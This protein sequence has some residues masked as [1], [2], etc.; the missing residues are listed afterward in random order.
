MQRTQLNGTNWLFLRLHNGA[1]E[2]QC[3]SAEGTNLPR[4]TLTP[5][6]YWR[7]MDVGELDL[8]GG[9]TME[10]P[11]S[12][13]IID[14]GVRRWDAIDGSVF[15]KMLEAELGGRPETHFRS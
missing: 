8:P 6:L 15:A 11:G 13:V 10:Y 9:V 5:E 12:Y 7:L 4:I 3:V 1:I 14:V 2:I